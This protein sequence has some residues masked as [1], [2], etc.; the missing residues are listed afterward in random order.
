MATEA[1]ENLIL[2]ALLVRAQA[3]VGGATYNTNPAV[4][5]V[6][7][8]HDSS[9][10]SG[11]AIYLQ[12]VDTDLLRLPSGPSHE[13]QAVFHAWCCGDTD[14]EALNVKDDLLRAVRAG[15]AALTAIATHGFRDGRCF[16][17]DP[18]TLEKVGKAVRVQEFIAAYQYQG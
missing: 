1:K 17:P 4:K 12:H 7:I 10:G 8:P 18:A 13:Y 16:I 9:A 6:G 11:Q 14:R 3:V 2:D 15:E 5:Q